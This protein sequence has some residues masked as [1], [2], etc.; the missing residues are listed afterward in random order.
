ME[1]SSELRA[2]GSLGGTTIGFAEAAN[3]GGGGGGASSL[4]RLAE[5]QYSLHFYVA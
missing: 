4:S 2:S 1:A 3:E 5:V